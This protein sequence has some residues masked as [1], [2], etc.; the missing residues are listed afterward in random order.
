[1]KNEK[2][3]GATAECIAVVVG[4]VTD[5]QFAI[6]YNKE[7]IAIYFYMFLRIVLQQNSQY[8]KTEQK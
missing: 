7:V 4:S 2:F 3:A 8:K 1:M 5:V 6:E